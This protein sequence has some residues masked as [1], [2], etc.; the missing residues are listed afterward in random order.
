METMQ[1]KKSFV[2]LKKRPYIRTEENII[3]FIS[4]DLECCFEIEVYE[5]N[6]IIEN[7]HSHW[8]HINDFSL[9]N[10][11]YMNSEQNQSEIKCGYIPTHSIQ[12]WVMSQV[13][14]IL[15]QQKQK[16]KGVTK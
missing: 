1:K 3:M 2:T 8:V 13:L 7:Y 10:I 4:P 6:K 12:I 14:N 16:T 11:F 15:R 9:S 5:N